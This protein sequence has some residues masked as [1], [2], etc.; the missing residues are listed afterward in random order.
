[1][2]LRPGVESFA[3]FFQPSGWSQ[4]F[5]SPI[6]EITNRI[7]DA[8]EVMGRCV[9]D[10]W[11]RLG[12]LSSFESRIAAA[13]EFLVQRVA[14]AN[15]KS[16]MAKTATHIFR[17]HGAVRIADLACHESMGLRHFE[18]QFQREIGATAKE[19]ARV[20]R[21]QT[22]VDAKLATPGRSWLDIAHSIGY[23]DQMHMIHD[24][25][26][27]GGNT[28]TN[29]ISQMGDVRPPAL[30]SATAEDYKFDLHCASEH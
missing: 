19:F 24:F 20:A 18:R 5:E 26:D 2:E 30:A 7:Y 4:L 17:S 6:S 27:L 9:R 11:N 28:P 13:E 25:R 10:L 8:R 23:C 16:Q 21:F 1:M 29:L 12:E 14:R 22:A 15:T 3:I